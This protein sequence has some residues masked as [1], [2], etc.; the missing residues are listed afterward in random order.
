[1]PVYH[2]VDMFLCLS[3]VVSMAEFH[4]FLSLPVKLAGLLVR[5]AEETYLWAG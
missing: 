1:M 5:E 4:F 2:P 3:C